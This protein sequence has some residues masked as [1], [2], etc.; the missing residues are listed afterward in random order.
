MEGCGKG[1]G[2]GIGG[3]SASVVGGH[4][5]WGCGRCGGCGSIPDP[6]EHLTKQNCCEHLLMDGKRWQKKGN[7]SELWQ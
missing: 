5:R 2:Q 4:G 1:R 7:Y 6:R 3:R